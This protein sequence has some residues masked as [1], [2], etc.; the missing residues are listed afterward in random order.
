MGGHESFQKPAYV[1]I[2]IQMNTSGLYEVVGSE[3]GSTPD[4]WCRVTEA[5]QPGEIILAYGTSAEMTPVGIGKEVI[6]SGRLHCLA[7]AE[8][9]AGLSADDLDIDVEGCLVYGTNE[10][11]S[12][13][14]YS[15]GAKSLWEAYSVNK[16]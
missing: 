11:G 5:E 3:Q 16:E 8:M 14:S 1:F 2:R 4:G 6:L 15:T 10:D 9:Y 13:G 12:D 7:D